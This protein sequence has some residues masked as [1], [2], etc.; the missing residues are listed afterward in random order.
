M[1]Y[2]KLDQLKTTAELARRLP[3][4]L[5]SKYHAIPVNEARARVTVAMADPTDFQAQAAITEGLGAKPYFVQA[6]QQMIDKCLEKTWLQSSEDSY[7]VLMWSKEKEPCDH[8]FSYAK[9]VTAL[10]DAQ[11][12]HF[13]KS[14]NIRDALDEFISEAHKQNGTL[15]ILNFPKQSLLNQ[16]FYNPPECQVIDRVKNSV[17][18]A[19]FPRW[20][21]QKI[22]L[23]LGCNDQDQPGV[24]WCLKIAEQTQ[25]EVT[26]LPL[27]IPSRVL[28]QQAGPD[29]HQLSDL[30]STD[31]NLGSKLRTTLQ[32]FVDEGIATTLRLREEPIFYQIRSEALESDY[33]L[34]ILGA[35]PKNRIQRL[36]HRDI[37]PNL[38]FWADRPVLIAR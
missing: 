11:I 22:L 32:N 3:Y 25:V 8:I 20:P 15:L 13:Q 21:I 30:L 17:L 27:M 31:C 2:L 28:L 6:D 19:R 35:Q 24:D 16:F 1:P 38:L 14:S 10:L 18:I 37:V 23:L 33:D 36:M 34:M 12:F 7:H 4:P 5:A 29:C 9:Q 26:I